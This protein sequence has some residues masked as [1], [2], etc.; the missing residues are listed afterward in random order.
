M[1]VNILV[2][3]A[4]FALSVSQLAAGRSAVKSAVCHLYVPRCR[5]TP[6]QQTVSQ[7]VIAF[8][9]YRGEIGSEKNCI[10]RVIVEKFNR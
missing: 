1:Q 8:L 2:F 7:P 3:I 6:T 10:N 5:S 9:E 4:F